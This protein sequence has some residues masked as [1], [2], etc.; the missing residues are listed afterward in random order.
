MACELICYGICYSIHRVQCVLQ[1]A[2]CAMTI[3]HGV[4]SSRFGS[5]VHIPRVHKTLSTDRVL[6]MEFVRGCPVADPHA[7]Q[8]QGIRPQAVARLIAQV[9]REIVVRPVAQMCLIGAVCCAHITTQDIL[10]QQIA[11]DTKEDCLTMRDSCVLPMRSHKIVLA[12]HALLKIPCP[13]PQPP[14]VHRCSRRWCSSLATCTATHTPPTCSC[15]AGAGAAHGLSCW[16]TA[17][18]GVCN[19]LLLAPPFNPKKQNKLEGACI[20]AAPDVR[21]AAGWAA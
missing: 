2:S 5:R 12:P 18:T 21:P 10:C 1:P 14:H 4:C 19:V 6:T 3:L 13:T 7:L 16:T 17:C 8:Q 15:N 11:L 20:D 9:R